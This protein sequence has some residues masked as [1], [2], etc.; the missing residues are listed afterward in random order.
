MRYACLV[1]L[2]AGCGFSSSA[3][4]AE[5]PGGSGGPNGPGG[6]GGSGSGSGTASPCDASN[7]SPLLC[8]AFGGLPM[9]Q[10]LAIPAHEILERTGI[11]PT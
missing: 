10:D 9:V 2:I 4:P 6:P 8:V 3:G 11:L 7:P 1:W 5:D